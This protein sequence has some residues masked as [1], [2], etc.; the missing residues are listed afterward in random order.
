MSEDVSPTF[1][2]LLH[3][4][5]VP[6]HVDA[7]AKAVTQAM[8]DAE[9]GRI[10]FARD[11]GT[12]RAAICFVPDRVLRQA[13]PGALFAV[14]LGL[15]DALGALAPPE[16]AVHFAWPNRVKVNGAYCGGLRAAAQY[17]DPD[18]EPDWLVIGVEVPVMPL[19]TRDPGHAPDETTLWEE[20][21]VDL[22]APQLIESW[23][24]HM[25]VWI[26][27]FVSDGIAPLHE[28]WRHKCDTLGEE[29]SAPEAGTFMGIDEDGGMILRQDGET[30]VVPLTTMLE[31]TG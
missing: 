23:S 14:L 6:A 20:G 21:C 7:F 27:R 31:G 30:R 11:S 12:M 25:L 3:G 4:V 22:G 16:V 28:G 18:S 29:V 24:R 26:N 2:P 9:P 17:N 19:D 8:V 5:E 13:L 1:P 10:T 15:N